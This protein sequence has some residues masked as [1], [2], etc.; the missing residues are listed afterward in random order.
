MRVGHDKTSVLKPALKLF[1]LDAPY[2]QL[3][4]RFARCIVQDLDSVWSSIEEF[5]VALLEALGGNEK[6]MPNLI[7]GR[8]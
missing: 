7:V 6:M 2:V 3:D 4:P 1:G 5:R 8:I